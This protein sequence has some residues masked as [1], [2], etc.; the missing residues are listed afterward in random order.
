MDDTNDGYGYVY[1]DYCI[2]FNY[3]DDAY[4]MHVIACKFKPNILA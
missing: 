3:I 4:F 2:Y 1:H